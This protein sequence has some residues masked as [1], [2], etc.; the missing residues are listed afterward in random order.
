MGIPLLCPD[1]SVLSKRLGT[2]GIKVPWYKKTDKL[3]EAIHATAID[4]TGLKRF[5]CGEWH[6]AKYELSGKAS[7]RKL[8]LAIN[9]DHYTR[10]YEKFPPPNPRG[11]DRG[12]HVRSSNL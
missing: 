4:S 2:L 7:W 1:F 8:H 9:Q 6:Q 10:L 11:A 3:D 12:A 5:G